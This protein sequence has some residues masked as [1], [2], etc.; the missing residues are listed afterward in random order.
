MQAAL[1]DNLKIYGLQVSGKAPKFITQD[2]TRI[3]KGAINE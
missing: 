1:V 2:E 3:L